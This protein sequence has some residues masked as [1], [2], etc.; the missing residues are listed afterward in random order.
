M[1]IF[2]VIIVILALILQ[3]VFIGKDLERVV[4][5]HRP[6]VQVAEPGE[7]F[8][9]QV[10]LE[11]QSRQFIPFLRVCEN[12]G[13]GF[14]LIGDE[15]ERDS[16][17]VCRVQFTTWLRPKQRLTRGIPVAISKRGRYVLR[18]FQLY[19]GDFLGLHERMKTSGRFNEV[20]VA[21]KEIAAKQLNDMF[22]GFMG[23]VSVNR[24]I[25]EDPVLT[26]GYREYTGRE[27]MKM[28][29]WSQS[30]RNGSLMVK[31]YDYTLEPTVAVILNVDT[32]NEEQ[33]EL[34]ETCFSLAR[35]VCAMLEQRGVKYSFSSNAIPAGAPFDPGVSR[36]GLGQRHFMGVL[37]HLGRATYAYNVSMEKLLE[38]EGNQGTAAGRILITPGR[39]YESVQA[40]NRLREASSGNLLVL[41]ATEVST[42]LS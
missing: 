13:E 25:M 23:E 37:E 39:G 14:F 22:G 40:L 24:F 34:L 7:P 6:S 35:S 18:E 42:W 17:G 11:N 20:V 30:A 33:E 38:K 29:S 8:Q 27:P 3:K 15:T 2:L 19:S 28:I 21:P 9:V 10:T 31:K 12:F 36:E 32:G 26:L 41:R 5:E 16:L 4:G 1:I